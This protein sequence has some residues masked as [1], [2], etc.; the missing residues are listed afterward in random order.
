VLGLSG[1]VSE[2]TSTDAPKGR[3]GAL[4]VVRGGHWD[5]APDEEEHTLAFANERSPRQF[6]FVLGVRCAMD[7]EKP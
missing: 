1:N 6:S 2:W 5:N 3:P 4:R 7:E